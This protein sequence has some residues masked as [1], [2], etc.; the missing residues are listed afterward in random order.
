MGMIDY[1]GY[2]L[3]GGGIV[4]LGLLIF[5]FGDRLRPLAPE[6]RKRSDA[7]ARENWGKEE[8]R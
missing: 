4:L 5:F 1:W 3:V 6:E 2:L 8:V 7:A